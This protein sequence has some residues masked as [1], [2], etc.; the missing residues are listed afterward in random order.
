M[1]ERHLGIGFVGGATFC[2]YTEEKARVNYRYYKK[3]DT[4]V[5]GYKNNLINKKFLFFARKKGFNNSWK[6]CERD[7]KR[8]KILIEHKNTYNIPIFSMN[9]KLASK[10]ILKKI[11]K[12]NKYLIKK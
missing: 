8:N 4:L 3:I 2:H 9:T 6:N 5:H 12:D 1:S 11:S 7:L 10:L